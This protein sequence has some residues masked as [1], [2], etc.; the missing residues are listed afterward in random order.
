MKHFLIGLISFLGLTMAAPAMSHHHH[1][2]RIHPGH[3]H[4]HHMHRHQIHRHWNSHH[5]WVVPAVI[6][7]TVIYAATRP[8]TVIVQPL[9]TV[10]ESNQVI[11]DGAVYE[12]QTMIINGAPQEVLVK[13]VVQKTFE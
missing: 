12:K 7:S 6:G 9:T 5:G 2:I 3:L 4:N 13:V 1:G 8:N 11:I 10:V